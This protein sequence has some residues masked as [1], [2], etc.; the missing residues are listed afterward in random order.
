MVWQTVLLPDAFAP[1][2]A[3]W[4]FSGFLGSRV[5][6][7]ALCVAIVEDQYFYQAS[8]ATAFKCGRCLCR[9]LDPVVKA[10]GESGCFNLRTSIRCHGTV[11]EL[12]LRELREMYCTP[13]YAHGPKV[14]LAWAV[15]P[16]VGSGTIATHAGASIRCS[17]YDVADSTLIS[18]S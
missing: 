5:G 11:F 18:M 6:A 17:T 13:Q 3:S 2:A 10:N 8:Q 9:G 4:S 12:E 14:A 1:S 15:I 16:K 7:D